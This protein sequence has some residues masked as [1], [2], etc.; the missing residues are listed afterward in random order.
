MLTEHMR[1]ARSTVRPCRLCPTHP[2]GS[3]EGETRVGHPKD[4]LCSH[5]K[6]SRSQPHNHGALLLRRR[7]NPGPAPLLA[8]SKE[9]GGL[10]GSRSAES[11]MEALKMRRRQ[12]DME[13]MARQAALAGRC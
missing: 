4:K 10:L 3:L 13:A 6:V 2:A 12:S 8:A 7:L 9:D 5:T 11:S 1:V